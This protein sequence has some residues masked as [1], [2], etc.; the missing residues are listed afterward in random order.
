MS[1]STQDGEEDSNI[2]MT[3]FFCKERRR[4]HDM[5]V[6]L[7]LLRTFKQK[8]PTNTLGNN[9]KSAVNSLSLI[10]WTLLLVHVN[11]S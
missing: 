9:A 5:G 4:R 1:Y 6:S 11:Y 2:I 10:A 7:L 8:L 3:I